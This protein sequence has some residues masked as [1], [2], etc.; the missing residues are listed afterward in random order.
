MRYISK[1]ILPVSSLFSKKSFSKNLGTLYHLKSHP[2]IPV[3][4]L[5]D[6]TY[7]RYSLKE[8]LYIFSE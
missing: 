4:L 3:L 5:Y 1:F 7:I 8:Q 6:F 2:S